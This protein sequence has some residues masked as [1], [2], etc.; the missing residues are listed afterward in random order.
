[1]NEKDLVKYLG[2]L[3]VILAVVTPLAKYV[4]MDFSWAVWLVALLGLLV[5]YFLK[6][7]VKTMLAGI[8][9]REMEDG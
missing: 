3:G 1:M 2:L 7:D 4:G 6:A 9:L 5:G 8:V